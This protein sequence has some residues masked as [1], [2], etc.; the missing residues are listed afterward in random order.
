[1]TNPFGLIDLLNTAERAIAKID[2]HGRRGTTMITY[3]EIEA[4]ALLAASSPVLALNTD[5][6]PAPKPQGETQ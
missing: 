1:M 6:T 4:L 3:D 5:P 2:R